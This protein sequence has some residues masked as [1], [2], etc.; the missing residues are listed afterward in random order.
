MMLKKQYRVI[1]IEH[2]KVTFDL[3]IDMPRPR[4]KGSAAFPHKWIG[5]GRG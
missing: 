1:L 3:V 4:V 2:G 5:F